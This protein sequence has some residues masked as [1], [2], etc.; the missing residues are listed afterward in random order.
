M[1]DL[2]NIK[3]STQRDRSDDTEGLRRFIAELNPPPGTEV[4]PVTPVNLAVRADLNPSGLAAPKDSS[5]LNPLILTDGKVSVGTDPILQPLL[6]R[7]TV[8]NFGPPRLS[9]L[10]S[11]SP[12][13]RPLG[14]NHTPKLEGKI[15]VVLPALPQQHLDFAPLDLSGKA[16]SK[17]SQVLADIQTINAAPNNGR[18]PDIA[19]LVPAGPPRIG[20]LAKPLGPGDLLVAAGGPVE[21]P[22]AAERRVRDSFDKQTPVEKFSTVANRMPE[23]ASLKIEGDKLTLATNFGRMLE[24]IP[25]VRLDANAWQTLN[26][27][28]AISLDGD[29]FTAELARPT[30][31]RGIEVNIQ[32]IKLGELTM[33][34]IRSPKVTFNVSFD[35]TAGTA[36][37]TNI[38]GLKLSAAGGLLKFSITKV[39]LRNKDDKQEVVAT[40]RAG[41]RDVEFALPSSQAFPGIEPSILRN[42]VGTIA[43]LKSVLNSRDVSRFA[44]QIPQQGLRELIKTLCKGVSSI[45]K[46]GD[47]FTIVRDNGTMIYDVGGTKVTVQNNVSFKINSDVSQPGL[48]DV[49]GLVVSLPLP[50]QLQLGS[51]YIAHIKSLQLGPASA[52]QTRDMTIEADNVLERVKLRV[53]NHL[54]PQPDAQ[55][56]YEIDVRA[57][58]IISDRPGDKLDVHL[59]LDKTGQL[60][61]TT[62]E[63]ADIVAKTSWQASDLSF[64]GA[65]LAVIAGGSKLASWG[66]QAYHWLFE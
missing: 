17:A 27:L 34:D 37:L 20:A 16:T 55:G 49:K 42:T 31:L 7:P 8:G 2:E 40:V 58:N 33:G 63:I 19:Q 66:A 6:N 23:Q 35:A 3:P 24:A 44:D 56:N 12:F 21:D 38:E 32:G 57:K 59:R 60:N 64:A 29:K 4:K 62:A 48:T 46:K 22:T 15:Q 28:Q 61:L 36:A 1:A 11:P 26:N 53:D 18:G 5:R 14:P 47:Q 65:G 41:S 25:G 43:D 52:D 50:D 10:T 45:D 30:V 51:R 13:D 9:Q 39:E 54:R